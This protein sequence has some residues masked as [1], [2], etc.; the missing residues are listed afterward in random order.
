MEF[1]ARKAVL[2]TAVATALAV[3][4]NA[5]AEQRVFDVP[6]EEAAK[7][8]PEFARQAGLQ[9]IAPADQLRGV[10][11]PAL[12]GPQDSRAALRILLAGTGL[13]VAA[14]DGSLITLHWQGRARTPQIGTPASE[15][16]PPSL[17]SKASA[18]TSRMRIG[19]VVV[20]AT[21]TGATNLQQTPVSDYVIPDVEIMRYNINNIKLLQQSS[22]GLKVTTS[23]INMQIYIRGVGGFNGG[24]S[25]VSVYLDGVYLSR[26]TTVLQSNFNDLDR[27]EI[28]EGPQG[29]LF[30]RNSTGGAIN[31]ISRAPTDVFRFSNTLSLGN[32]ALLDEAASVSGPIS[33]NVQAI[34]SV[35]HMQHDGY[36]HNVNPGVGDPAAANRTAVRGQLRWEPTADINNTVRADYIY[37]HERWATNDT[38]LSP[39]A[40]VTWSEPLLASIN[41][42]F[43]AVD[44]NSTPYQNELAYG[45]SDE[46]SWTPNE[47]FTVRSLAAGRTDDSYLAQDGLTQVKYSFGYAHY[48]EYQLSE[49]L[50]LINHI[51]PFSGIVGI[52]YF[53]E[54]M[55]ILGYSY[56]PGGNAKVPDPLAG[57]LT[58]QDTLQPTIAKAIFFDETY[59]ITP[60]LGL[61]VGA[62]YTQEHKTLNTD[63]STVVYAPGY[64][65]NGA[66][67]SPAPG[68][69]NPFV[70]DL[71]KDAH[72]LTPK[73]ALSWQATPSDLLYVSATNSYKSGG[74][75]ST[76]RAVL[77]A[78][79]GPERIWAYELGAKTDWFDR[80]LRMNIAAFHYYWTGLQFNALVAPQI[81]VVSN[82]AAATLDGVEADITA[83]PMAGFTVTANATL[84]SSRYDDF[85]AFAF[86]SALRPFLTSDPHYDAS[87]GAYN[88]SGKQLINAPGVTVNLSVQKDFDLADGADLFVRAEYAY[89]SKTFLDPT[90]VAIASRP[91]FSLINASIGFSP[92]RSHWQAAIWGKNLTDRMY[93]NGIAGGSFVTAPVGD[94][95]T[96]GVRVSYTY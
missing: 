44:V 68:A 51:G 74:Y 14:D 38:F 22:P 15:S 8:I 40:G 75:N 52:Y 26:L 21:K 54:N 37:T 29:T 66:F 28:I 58:A 92:P 93:I 3:A 79:F 64:P 82:A 46:L 32:Y 45:L 53:S 48:K 6:S 67:T 91:A 73:F 42:N 5:T 13:S 70:A 89:T 85:K 36:L 80:R 12:K 35:G 27:V 88:A 49:E 78:D 17:R 84:L 63:N 59:Q 95:R 71:N 33:N 62:R 20:T 41:G 19:E 94:P 24:E 4:G 57:N 16:R 10:S 83:K 1:V 47:H 9:I 55:N 25:D 39:T 7:A 30:G 96:F 18:L 86:Q 11:T 31:L 77:G 87:T 90:N 65:G 61:S 34:M 76:A 2:A 72:A 56:N 23:N 60:T 50:T 69:V 81:S 43:H